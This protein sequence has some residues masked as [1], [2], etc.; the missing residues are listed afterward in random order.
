MKEKNIYF[1]YS[2][3]CVFN[4]LKNNIRYTLLISY[5]EI[6]IFILEFKYNVYLINYKFLTFKSGV[7]NLFGARGQQIKKKYIEIYSRQAFFQAYK[8]TT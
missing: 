1:Y 2:I 8:V 5:F 4:L 6:G 3:I 7:G